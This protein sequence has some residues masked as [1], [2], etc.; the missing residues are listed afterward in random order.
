MAMRVPM[1]TMRMTVLLISTVML[2]AGLWFALA[3]A[4]EVLVPRRLPMI[5]RIR[6][7][8][9]YRIR[10]PTALVYVCKSRRA[11]R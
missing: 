8:H 5:V 10:R 1:M 4:F 6:W 9:V 3:A 2:V 11:S 7:R